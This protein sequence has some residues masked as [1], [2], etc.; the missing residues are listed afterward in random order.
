METKRKHQRLCDKKKTFWSVN[1]MG[2]GTT[3]RKR[4]D[5]PMS[6][7][8]EEKETNLKW[9]ILSHLRELRQN[10]FTIFVLPVPS[11]ERIW[12]FLCCILD[13]EPVEWLPAPLRAPCPRSAVCLSQILD[14][15]NLL[16]ELRYPEICVFG[17]VGRKFQVFTCR[18]DQAEDQLVRQKLILHLRSEMSSAVNALFGELQRQGI[19][20]AL[21]GLNQSN[22]VSY[23]P[24]GSSS[25][26][27]SAGVSTLQHRL[28]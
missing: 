19:I 6:S 26:A 14:N 12:F 17:K 9:H 13:G 3:G 23:V 22:K 10:A 1:W 21:K 15:G 8:T 11:I 28:W 20:A 2:L 5:P 24:R 27:S 25:G 16:Q 4:N 18:T 7:T